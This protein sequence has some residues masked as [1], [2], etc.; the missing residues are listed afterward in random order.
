MVLVRVFSNRKTSPDKQSY[1][2]QLVVRLFGSRFRLLVFA[3][4]SS[5]FL[6]VM[7]V[8]VVGGNTTCSGADWL[9]QLLVQLTAA[10]GGSAKA[11]CPEGMFSY[12][13]VAA[14]VSNSK[15]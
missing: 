15:A 1:R 12:F 10:F 2:L 7:D 9:L 6:F 11:F 14:H 3:F 13:S 4:S 5:P 8:V